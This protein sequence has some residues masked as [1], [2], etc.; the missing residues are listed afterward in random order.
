MLCVPPPTCDKTAETARS[1]KMSADG[2]KIVT[3]IKK[4]RSAHQCGSL[5]SP[6]SALVSS[7]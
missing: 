1:E 5:S 6:Q 4:D 2:G 7:V 3:V